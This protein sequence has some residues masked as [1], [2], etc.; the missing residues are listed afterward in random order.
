MD[1]VTRLNDKYTKETLMHAIYTAMGPDEVQ[2][3][4]LVKATEEAAIRMFLFP[5]LAGNNNEAKIIKT[6]LIDLRCNGCF[7]YSQDLTE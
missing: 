5:Y 7:R 3:L 6:A 4:G 2:A 1:L